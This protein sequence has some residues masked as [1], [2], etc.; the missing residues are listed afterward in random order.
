M[1]ADQVMPFLNTIDVEGLWRAGRQV[2]D[3]RLA[4]TRT[5]LGLRDKKI[6]LFSGRLYAEKRVDFLLEAFARIQQHCP[7]TALLILGDGVERPKLEA[8]CHKLHLRDVYFLGEITDTRESSMYF[9]LAQLLVI[10]GLVGLAIVHGFAFNL[11]LI[12]TEQA[13]H[14]PEIEYLTKHNGAMTPHEPEA[15]AAEI[16]R[17]LSSPSLHH[18]MQ[19]Q[20]GETAQQLTV[21]A[22]AM[23]FMLAVN[24][25]TSPP[26]PVAHNRRRYERTPL[27]PSN[28]AA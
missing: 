6:L 22:S 3:I 5:R 2:T 16:I 15:Y 26:T 18:A 10:P 28:T 27:G 23:R 11:P 20:A 1:S 14:G 12:T 13:G 24:R 4:R 19:T 21:S 17:V 25:F 7:K 9:K 8:L